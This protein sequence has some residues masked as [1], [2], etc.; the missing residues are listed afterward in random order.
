MAHY[1]DEMQ[2]YVE[3]DRSK[4]LRRDHGKYRP[5]DV[6]I[7]VVLIASILTFILMSLLTSDG[8]EKDL[9]RRC[10]AGS[11]FACARIK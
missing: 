11:A 8:V 6:L 3:R 2:R 9:A 1:T 10:R 5:A 7:L 4:F